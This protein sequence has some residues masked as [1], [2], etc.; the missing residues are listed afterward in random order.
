MKEFKGTKG[1]WIAIK[2]DG[3]D[4]EVTSNG[5][6]ICWLVFNESSEVEQAADAQLIA[7]APNLLEALQECQKFLV[8]IGSEESGMA[9]GKN[10]NAINKAL[11]Q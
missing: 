6:E 10:M 7:A 1:E 5:K 4:Y 8:E 11:N 3:Y 2:P 9:Y